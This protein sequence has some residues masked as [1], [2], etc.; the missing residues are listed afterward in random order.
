MTS[1]WPTG[2]CGCCSVKD[3]GCGC[4][5]YNCISG[6]C[7][8]C[9]AL[10]M[11]D[12]GSCCQ[13]CLFLMFPCYQAVMRN[14]VAQKYEIKESMCMS[15]LCTLFCPACSCLQVKNAVI[16]NENMTW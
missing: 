3:C 11:A 10:N 12:L 13:H 9:H 8:L 4:L 6:P 14:R 5:M 1:A 2:I 16:V 7:I 15:C